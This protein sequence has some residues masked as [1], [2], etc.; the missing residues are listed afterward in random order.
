MSHPLYPGE[1]FPADALPSVPQDDHTGDGYTWMHDLP[2]GWKAVGVW[3][4]DGWDLGVWPYQVIAHYNVLDV[5]W[6][7][8]HYIEGDVFVTAYG[9]REARDAATD[10]IA[11]SVW[12]TAGNGPR[13]GLPAEGAPAAAI[14][15]RFRGP[16]LPAPAAS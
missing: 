4:A 13:E 15:A 3:G 10:E 14:P 8:A 12:L 7:L 6:G 16:Y 9:S 5:L 2:P 1:E 11:L